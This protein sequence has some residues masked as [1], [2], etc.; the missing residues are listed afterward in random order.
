MD[1]Y[2]PMDIQTIANGYIQ[3]N[4]YTNYSKWIYTDQ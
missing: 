3:T 4:G 1:R 2:R